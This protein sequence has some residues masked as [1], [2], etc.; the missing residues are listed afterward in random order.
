MMDALFKA[1]GFPDDSEAKAMKT[2]VVRAVEENTKSHDDLRAALQTIGK[3]ME[4]CQ[5]DTRRNC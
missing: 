1:F 3:Q 5:N 2:A 4:P